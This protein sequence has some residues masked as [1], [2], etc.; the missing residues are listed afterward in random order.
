LD[1]TAVPAVIV[2]PLIDDTL[3]GDLAATVVQLDKAAN[4]QPAEPTEAITETATSLL[5]GDQSAVHSA[6]TAIM[7]ADAAVS[8]DPQWYWRDIQGHRADSPIFEPMARGITP[9]AFGPRPVAPAPRIGNRVPALI[10]QAQDDINSQLP[11]AEA[12]HRALAGSRMIVLNGA[13]THG[14]YLFRGSA[15]VD[16]TV[17]A[18]LESGNLP[19]AD[20]T[21][22]Q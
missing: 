9:C 5:T 19:G 8:R 1:D 16:D 12:M 11:G 14:V 20:V 4:G 17:N 6:Q 13:R 2:D 3:N 21:C 7:C 22:A 10:V 15:C 18:Y